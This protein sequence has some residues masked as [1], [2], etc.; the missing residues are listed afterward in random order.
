MSSDAQADSQDAQLYTMSVDLSVLEAL[1]INL[2]SNAAAVLSELVA[3]AYDADAT[4]V[5]ISWKEDGKT[6]VVTDNGTGMDVEEINKR[7][8]T[9]GYKKRD[10][11]GSKST[12]WGRPFMGRKG[13]G[14]LSVFSIADRVLVYTTKEG[15]PHGLQIVVSELQTAIKA[16]RPYHPK[17]V[18]VPDEY[19]GPGTTLGLDEL[20]TKRADLTV[21]AL[22]KRLARRFDVLD[23]TP[24]EEGGFHIKVNGKRITYADRQELT[25]LEFIWEFGKE[26]LPA[27]ALPSGIKRF[28]LANDTIPGHSDWKVKGWIGTARKPRI[29]PMTKRLAL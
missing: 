25:K 29:S 6:I 19:A 11:E 23:Q 14:K 2:Y 24:S 8:L 10:E 9:V 5:E 4:Q 27:S 13:I 3:N 26:T 22:R 1:G 18:G 28:V 7:F 21:N 12:K 15:V 17:P 20:K 16:K